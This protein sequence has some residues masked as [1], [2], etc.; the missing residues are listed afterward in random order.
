MDGIL[1]SEGQSCISYLASASDDETVRIWKK[2][3]NY[4]HT[5]VFIDFQH[6]QGKEESK[7]EENEEEEDDDD[8]VIRFECIQVYKGHRSGTLSSSLSPRCNG[9]VLESRRSTPLFLLC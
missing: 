9:F 3:E 4:V 2:D 8:D 1:H 5:F 6:P 7:E